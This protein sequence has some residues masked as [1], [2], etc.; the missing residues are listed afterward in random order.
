MSFPERAIAQA[1]TVMR[2]YSRTTGR[3]P[4]LVQLVRGQ[5]AEAIAWRQVATRYLT[6]KA[7]G[8]K[9][10]FVGNIIQ[11]EEPYDYANSDLVG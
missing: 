2:T 10:D 4:L 8:H 7:E 6:A 1:I 5:S 11:K 3:F 9:V